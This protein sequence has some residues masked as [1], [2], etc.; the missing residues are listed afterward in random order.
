MAYNTGRVV[1]RPLLLL[2]AC[3]FTVCRCRATFLPRPPP[4]PPPSDKP[5]RHETKR[6][7]LPW[8]TSHHHPPHAPLTPLPLFLPHPRSGYTC[9]TS[10]PRWCARLQSRPTKAGAATAA[11]D[12]EWA[13]DT[14][15]GCPA[16]APNY[17]PPSP[18]PPRPPTHRGPHLYPPPRMPSRLPCIRLQTHPPASPHR[19]LAPRSCLSRRWRLPCRRH[20]PPQPIWRATLRWSQQAQ[21]E[22]EASALLA[23]PRS[24]RRSETGHDN[25]RA[26]HGM[27]RQLWSYF[28]DCAAVRLL[29]TNS[30]VAGLGVT[31]LPAF[32]HHMYLIARRL[33]FIFAG[34]AAVRHSATSLPLSLCDVR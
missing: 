9:T 25:A 10:G 8:E 23:S 30:R 13:P 1:S 27:A 20:P 16:D 19:T 4:G 32:V 34:C 24:S 6:T 5:A 28:S 14:F 17:P 12:A 18:P 21:L 33:P 26:V 2:A 7:T 22:P 29:R 11:S 15:I 3:L 31:R